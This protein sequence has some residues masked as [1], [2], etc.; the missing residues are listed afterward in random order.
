[1]ILLYANQSNLCIFIK[2]FYFDS[3]LMAD[4]WFS[5]WFWQTQN[6]LYHLNKS[7]CNVKQI[8]RKFPFESMEFE[9]NETN[10]IIFHY[11]NVIY[12][13]FA[14][15]KLLDVK[16]Q[17]DNLASWSFIDVWIVIVLKFS[18]QTFRWLVC[19]TFILFSKE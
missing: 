6:S 1:M 13:S 8:S 9:L 12:D 5:I 11:Y 3:A 10:I 17:L 18:L 15:I 7:T 2:K 16:N 14:C 4:R 19:P